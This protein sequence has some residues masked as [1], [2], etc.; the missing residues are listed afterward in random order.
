MDIFQTKIFVLFLALMR[1]LTIP[2]QEQSQQ[3]TSQSTANMDLLANEASAVPMYKEFAY[4]YDEFYR[5]KNYAQE[6]AFLNTIFLDRSIETLLDIGC[7]T[8]NHLSLLEKNGYTCTGMD[9]NQE[10]LEVAKPKIT[11]ELH[12]ANMTSFDF[13]EKYD[14]IISM[15]AVF[16]HN[17][18]IDEAAKTLNCI[19]NHLNP[20]GLVILDLYNPQSSGKKTTQAGDVE[21]IME[22]HFKPGD[23]IALTRLKFNKGDQSVESH[24]PLRIY[25][26]DELETLFQAH[27]FKNVQFYEDYT[28]KPG[29]PSS[30][31]L[32]VVARLSE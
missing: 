28:F 16:N 5:S 32:I 11:G 14:A 2:E 20:G 23:N 25:S 3:S 27:G 4:L 21:R 30:K 15:F 10:M 1:L 17:L 29:S 13:R 9:I 7:G 24:F 31:N 8:G 18:T 6:V 12:L 26:M 19:K 22:W